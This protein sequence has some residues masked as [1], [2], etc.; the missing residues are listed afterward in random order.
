[1]SFLLLIFGLIVVV[2]TAALVHNDSFA[3]SPH[4]AEESRT[5]RSLAASNMIRAQQQ[6]PGIK[7]PNL[8]V[9]EVI[10]GLNLPTKMAFLGS[11]DFIVLE[12]NGTVRRVVD[13]KLLDQPLL[14]VNVSSGT[15]QGMLGIAVANS[16][17][18]SSGNNNSSNNNNSQIPLSP[19]VFLFYTEPKVNNTTSN[20]IHSTN[21]S[22]ANRLYRYDLVNNMLENPKLLLDLPATPNSMGNGGAIAIGPD[23]NV[24][25]TIGY[26]AGIGG[27]PNNAFPQTMTLNY[28][29][30]TVIDGRSG[31]LM[32]TQ[33]RNP[34]LSN[35]NSGI[36]GNEYP[37]NLYYGYGI[38]NSYGI[39]FDPKTG[40][41][42]D[43]E[44]NLGIH[45]E[46]NLVKPGYNGG[47]AVIGGLS[48]HAPAAP[49]TLVDFGG[50]GKYSDPEFEWIVKPGVAALRF[51]TSDKLGSQ[52]ENDLFVGGFHDGILYH[53]KLNADRTG[54]FL[55]ESLSSKFIQT[56]NSSIANPI[57]FGEGFG[58]I[59]DITV[60]PDGYL[61]VVS[62][63]NG[64]IYKIIPLNQ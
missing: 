49:S 32:I 23:G 11:D 46:I 6:M 21:T 22:V 14:N 51:L 13:S 57:I 55:P 58:G 62:V 15:Y 27:G 9:V 3:Y 59:S 17:S 28:R 60:G 37:L 56:S 5:L 61:Y 38:G 7:D 4:Q 30:S 44:N 2:D 16:S 43:I 50:K 39:D 20:D 26:A 33:D 19:Y 41:L 47:W 48:L 36:L 64:K 18:I 31:I 35:N 54:L 8:E 10:S 24:F 12:K 52:Y 25:V 34:V 29:N 53:F 63:A 40:N 42:W 1:M 45:D